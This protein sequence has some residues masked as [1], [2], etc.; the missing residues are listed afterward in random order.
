MLEAATRA[1]RVVTKGKTLVR[2]S[3]PDVVPD[4]V[5]IQKEPPGREN[6]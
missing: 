4:C 1:E 6:V 2:E 5:N 3:Q